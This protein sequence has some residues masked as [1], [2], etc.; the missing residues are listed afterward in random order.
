MAFKWISHLSVSTP[1]ALWELA[2]WSTGTQTG[3]GSP[4]RLP[5]K[6]AITGHQGRRDSSAKTPSAIMVQLAIVWCTI[7]H[8]LSHCLFSFRPV[9]LPLSP[10][11]LCPW[12]RS[13]LLPS[14]TH[15]P[16][17]PNLLNREEIYISDANCSTSACRSIKH[18]SQHS[19]NRK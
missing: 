13:L 9:S 8:S 2:S 6:A 19:W 18:H 1:A 17:L 4:E 7:F 11:V 16:T 5:V 10:S 15:V 12:R 14:Y 3:I